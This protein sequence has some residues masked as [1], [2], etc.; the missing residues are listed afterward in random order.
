MDDNSGLV[1][2]KDLFSC[3]E[4]VVAIQK[5]DLAREVLET[6][7][8]IGDRALPVAHDGTVEYGDIISR[9]IY[10]R[11]LDTSSFRMIADSFREYLAETDD[12]VPNFFF[13]SEWVPSYYHRSIIDITGVTMPQLKNI[14]KQAKAY[15]HSENRRLRPFLLYPENSINICMSCEFDWVSK[16]LKK[17]TNTDDDKQDDGNK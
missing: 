6:V 1:M 17:D 8:A 3:N 12:N 7:E 15:Y 4:I 2:R 9:R 5:P 16:T 13:G 10:A 14:L 11:I